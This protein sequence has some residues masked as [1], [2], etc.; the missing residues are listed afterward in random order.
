MREIR[1][2][3]PWLTGAEQRAALIREEP[4]LG[5]AV[6]IVIAGILLALVFPLMLVMAAAILCETSG[7]VFE[8]R[9]RV[10][11]SGRRQH[12]L[13]FRITSGPNVRAGAYPLQITVV[14]MF[15]RYASCKYWVATHIVRW[16]HQFG[17]VC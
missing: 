8:N 12:V 11:R 15:L 2:A 1:V 3:K 6:D 7:P 14:G 13:A 9:E 17:D 16:Q 10:S 4:D 5:T